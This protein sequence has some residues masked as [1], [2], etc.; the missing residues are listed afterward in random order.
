M[1]E[2]LKG[3]L[4]AALLARFGPDGVRDMQGLAPEEM[5]GYGGVLRGTFVNSPDSVTVRLTVRPWDSDEKWMAMV[6]GRRLGEERFYD[7]WFADSSIA[8]IPYLTE[9]FACQCSAC[10]DVPCWHGGA[11]TWNWLHRAQER[12]ELI[13]LLLNRRGMVRSMNINARAVSRV[14]TA[15]GT[16]LDRTRKEL[17]AIV[18]AA[19]KAAQRERDNLFGES[20][21]ANAD[22]R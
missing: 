20:G 7:D 13:L 22:S 5:Q 15:L 3:R 4:E 10:G 19:V 1:L 14:P 21:S 12:P 2:V 11:L 17:T 18:E 9:E 16:N 8:R 6:E